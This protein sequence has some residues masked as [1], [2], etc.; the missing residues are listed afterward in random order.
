VLSVARVPNDDRRIIAAIVTDLKG[1][2]VT[3]A[4]RS[5]RAYLVEQQWTAWQDGIERL[6]PCDFG[7]ADDSTI[8]T[9]PE[10]ETAA[11]EL[12]NGIF[13]APPVVPAQADPYLNGINP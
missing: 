11:P 3:V 13:F 7:G 12:G 5:A 10:N 1:Q 4:A 8:G 9:N 2:D 6:T